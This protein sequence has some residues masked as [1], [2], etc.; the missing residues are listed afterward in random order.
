MNS[1]FEGIGKVIGKISDQVQGRIERLKNEKVSLIN[2]RKYLMEKPKTST[3]INRILAID[4]R[5][6]E[7]SSILENKSSD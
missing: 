3:T 2:E 6:S 7:V 1:L 4:D 5:L